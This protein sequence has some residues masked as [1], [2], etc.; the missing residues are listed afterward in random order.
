MI[1]ILTAL[2]QTLALLAFVIYAT[3]RPTS[4]VDRSCTP[5]DAADDSFTSS[6]MEMEMEEDVTALVC[7][8]LFANILPSPYVQQFQ[9]SISESDDAQPASADAESRLVFVYSLY[10]TSC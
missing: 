7:A 4:Q 5:Q 2:L 1:V 6:E 3:T 9:G 8:P 10:N